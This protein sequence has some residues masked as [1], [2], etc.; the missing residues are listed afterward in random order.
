M[1]VR[2][3]L[4]VRVIVPVRHVD[5]DMEVA[6]DALEPELPDAFPQ[7]FLRRR[8]EREIG[9]IPADV[10]SLVRGRSVHRA[11]CRHQ[12]VTALMMK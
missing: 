3:P 1:I 7:G 4:D 2:V 10:K 5:G 11:L 9:R 6:H 12:W 8:A